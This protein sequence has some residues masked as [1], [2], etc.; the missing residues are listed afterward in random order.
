MI[1]YISGQVKQV[2]KEKLIIMT[3]GG[4]GYLVSAVQSNYLEG[5]SVN[6]YIYTA[7]RETEISL[8]GFAERAELE[9]F[10][11]LLSVSGVG[12]KTA[13][14]L[15][16]NLGVN[17]IISAIRSGDAL[18][19]KVPGVGSKISERIVIDLKNKVENLPG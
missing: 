4:V 14:A 5:Q 13:Q 17:R 19:L 12:L 9:L 10:E 7:V 1:G 18:S 6:L 16:A 2:Y 15:I 8:W 3:G 11:S